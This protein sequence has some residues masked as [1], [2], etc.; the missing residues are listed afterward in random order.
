MATYHYVSDERTD[1]VA[2][3]RLN[4]PA[5]LNAW[6]T[7][8]GIELL[9]AFDRAE[10]ECRAIVIGSVGRAF[11]SGANLT[12]GAFRMDDPERDAGLAIERTVNP[13]LLR[14]R[15]S[16]VPVITAVRGA[17]A[18]VGCGIALSGDLV[19]AGEGAY[20]FQAFSKVGLVPDGGSTYFLA[21]TIGRVRA[22]ELMLLGGKLPA[23]QARDWGLVNRIVPDEEVDDAALAL[24]KAVAV[25]PRSL[26]MIRAAGWSAL[27]TPF[28][29]QIEIERQGQRAAGLTEDFAEG[30]R[31]FKEKRPPVFRG[32]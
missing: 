19:V 27:D 28:E 20:F 8:M 23:P 16:R 4:D 3:L 29:A 14:I 13:L 5:T 1:D 6:S 32:R 15:D 7:D 2:I 9:D 18:G 11:C 12:S 21:R 10:Q 22:M 17:A 30:V 25:G 31:A 26:G 24:A